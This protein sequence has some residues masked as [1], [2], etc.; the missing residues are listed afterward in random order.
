MI[1]TPAASLGGGRAAFPAAPLRDL[2]ERAP[3]LA[4]RLPVVQGGR[5]SS[6]AETLP[7]RDN[8]GARFANHQRG[9][10]WSRF[11]AQLRKRPATSPSTRKRLP[12]PTRPR[13]PSATKAFIFVS[14]A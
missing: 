11:A 1:R 7:P 13:P 14:R 5:V 4:R 2:R 8:A 12:P 6:V 9:V 3:R 10:T